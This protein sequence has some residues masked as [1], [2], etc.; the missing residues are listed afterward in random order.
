LLMFT[1]NML[2][3]GGV[4]SCSPS[5]SFTHSDFEGEN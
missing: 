1:L 4:P 5:E 3:N 2:F